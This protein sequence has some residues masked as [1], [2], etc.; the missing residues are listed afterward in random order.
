MAADKKGG[1]GGALAKRALKAIEEATGDHVSVAGHAVIPE[2]KLQVYE[3]VYDDYRVLQREVELL[4]YG[5]FDFL[6][7]QPQEIAS[8]A[9]RRI[10]QRARTVWANDPQAGA[11]VELMNDFVFGRGVPK[12]RA[13]DKIVQEVLD[14]FWDDPDNQEVLT[15]T[16]A[17]L[18]VGTDLSLQSNVF[19]LIF[20]DGDDGKV[21]LSILRHD[22]V[23]AAVP[24]PEKRHRVLYFLAK[25]VRIDWD[26]AQDQP[27]PP[28]VDVNQ[29]P[30]YYE[31]WRNLEL[32]KEEKGREQPIELAP[33]DRVKPGRVYHLRINR[34]SEQIFGVP[35]FQRTLRWYTAYN[36]YVKDR[37]DIVKAAA[38]VIMKRKVKG[39]PAQLEK[40]ATQMVARSGTLASQIP[41]PLAMQAGGLGA[42]GI[43][44]ENDSVSHEPLNLDTRAGNAAQDA[45]MIRAPISAAERWTQ[46]Y[47][48]DASNSSLA[49]ATSLELPILKMVESRQ[50]VFEA[51]FRTLLDRQIEKAVESGRIPKE[52][53][54]GEQKDSTRPLPEQEIEL[55]LVEACHAEVNAGRDLVELAQVRGGDEGLWLLVS[56]DRDGLTHYTI[57]ES[58]E[59]QNKDEADTLRDLSYEFSMPSPLRRMMSDLI[60]SITTIAQTFDPNNTN[61]NL[62]RALLTIALGEGLEV[63]D[64][65]DLVEQIFPDGYV[66]PML[67]AQMDQMGID[68]VTGRPKPQPTQG[69]G[70]Q[71]AGAGF[72][73][74]GGPPAPGTGYGTPTRAPAQARTPEQLRSGPYNA[75]EGAADEGTYEGMA[76]RARDGRRIVLGRRPELPAHEIIEAGIDDLDETQRA[77]LEGRRRSLTDQYR[78]DVLG[79]AMRELDAAT[80]GGDE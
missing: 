27:M 26:Y 15:S 52:Y 50:E 31:H 47:F 49:T 71:D 54:P 7:Q 29:K 38:Q 35:R 41:P 51:L 4:G 64:A 74:N 9:R 30:F 45:Q 78:E 14:E 36:D 17:Q 18:A 43:L 5:L 16:E 65:S 37:L 56:R 11:A 2:E 76:L 61:V 8:N 57:V 59:D 34:G 24:D 66:D 69:F 28:K 40:I 60:T 48:G 33:P 1:I 58:Y 20:D 10:V 6:N 80:Y 67:G 23:Q 55:A 73:A 44:N 42:A 25:H 75:M 46:A 32:A 22:D 63:Q 77:A 53:G 3:A 79:P 13:K 21:K 19:V 70:Q 72:P 12:P 68:P 39:T 62:S